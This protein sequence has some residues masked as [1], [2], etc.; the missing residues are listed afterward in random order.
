MATKQHWEN[1]YKAKQPDE[2]SWFQPT[3][4]TSLEFVKYFAIPTT[5]K[6]IDVG[7]C[8]SLFVEHLLDL[9][10]QDVTVDHTT[11]FDTVQ[12]F[13]FCGF[14]RISLS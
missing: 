12:N 4:S 7:G 13:I 2:E 10:Y 9:G 5:A 8:D 6:I 3:P 14:R 1:I 11:L